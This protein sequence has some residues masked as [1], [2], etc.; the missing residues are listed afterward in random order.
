[1]GTA[2]LT[3]N[4]SILNPF[5]ILIGRRYASLDPISEELNATCEKRISEVSRR[6]EGRLIQVNIEGI[7]RVRKQK[8]GLDLI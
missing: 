7:T 3:R 5:Q 6:K 8:G 4:F 2:N 1:M